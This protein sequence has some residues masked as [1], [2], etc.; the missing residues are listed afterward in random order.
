MAEEVKA[1]VAK[2]L[3][4]MTELAAEAIR[5][6]NG[7]AAALGEIERV[8]RQTSQRA[9][10]PTA[11]RPGAAVSAF[12]G[13]TPRETEVLRLVAEGLSNSEIAEQLVISIKT[14]KT[15]M[16]SLLAKLG[17]RDRSQLVIAAY[18]AGLIAP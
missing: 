14:V 2:G 7:P 3:N 11:A 10:A 13:L 6:N 12:E 4:E 18:Q 16:G 15:H 9:A 1:I 5:S 17:A 8:G